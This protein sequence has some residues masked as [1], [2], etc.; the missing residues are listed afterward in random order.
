MATHASLSQH[1]VSGA[2]CCRRRRTSKSCG[3]G[4][5]MI[6]FSSSWYDVL[7]SSSTRVFKATPTPRRTSSRSRALTTHSKSLD[8]NTVASVSSY[9]LLCVSIKSP[10]R[11]LYSKSTSKST[12]PKTKLKLQRDSDKK[13]EPFPPPSFGTYISHTRTSECGNFTATRA[14]SQRITSKCVD[15]P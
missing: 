11:Q 2:N 8:S 15:P 3:Q 13:K 14:S 10:P 1:R 12:R 5:L 4:D 7:S 6:A 9:T